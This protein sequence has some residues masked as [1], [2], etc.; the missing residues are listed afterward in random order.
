MDI[1]W[2]VCLALNIIIPTEKSVFPVFL[3]FEYFCVHLNNIHMVEMGI[4]P[5]FES[6]ARFGHFF[7]YR[8]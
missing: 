2:K 1:L 8:A 6:F 7:I 4:G 3:P 5:I